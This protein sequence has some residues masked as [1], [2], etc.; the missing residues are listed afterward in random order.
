MLGWTP[1]A[2]W[3]STP[4]E[5]LSIYRCYSPEPGAPPDAQILRKLKEQFPDGPGN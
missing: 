4:A 5:I 2:F 3:R 1:D